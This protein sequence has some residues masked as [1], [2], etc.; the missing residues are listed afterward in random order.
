MS[1]AADVIHDQLDHITRLSDAANR[2]DDLEAMVETE[3]V[4]LSALTTDRVEEVR[5][6]HDG[7]VVETDIR[8]GTYVRANDLLASVVDNLLRNAVEHGDAE[9]RVWVTVR[10][11]EGRSDTAE[12]RVRDDGPGFSDTELAVHTDATET[13]LQHSDGVGLW[14]VRWIV[15]AYDGELVVEN[16]ATG[17]AVTV[18]LPAARTPTDRQRRMPTTAPERSATTR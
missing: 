12:L 5:R 2:L 18:R 6:V 4:D 16:D 1:E 11:T 10:P 14:L 7:V 9:P 3:P 17:A 8:P 15:D 13:A